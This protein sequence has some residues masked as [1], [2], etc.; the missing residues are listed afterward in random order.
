VIASMANLTERVFDVFD[1]GA[2]GDFEFDEELITYYTSDLLDLILRCMALNPSNRPTFAGILKEISKH[3][4]S[5]Q[6]GLRDKPAD[7]DA[8][9]DHLLLDNIMT[10]VRI[11][12]CLEHNLECLLTSF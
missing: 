9:D 5:H 11:R 8:W 12:A 3:R 2:D 7:D 10:L 6:H 1:Q 4:L